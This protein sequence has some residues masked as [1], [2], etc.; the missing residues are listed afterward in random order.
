MNENINL[1]KKNTD[2]PAV[3]ERLISFLLIH[4]SFALIL[5]GEFIIA[6]SNKQISIWKPRH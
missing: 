6:A 5:V 1:K 3:A 4:N 2:Q